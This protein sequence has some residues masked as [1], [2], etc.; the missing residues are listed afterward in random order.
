MPSSTGFDGRLNVLGAVVPSLRP[1]VA[2]LAARIL[3]E[4][5]VTL[6]P[7]EVRHIIECGATEA[8]FPEGIQ[9]HPDRHI[10]E[11]VINVAKTLNECMPTV[12]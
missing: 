4:S 7:H 6:T 12:P 3:S 5:P 1:M 11:G 10:G 9:G 2:G 8:T